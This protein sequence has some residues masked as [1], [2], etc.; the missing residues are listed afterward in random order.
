MNSLLGQISIT[1]IFVILLILAAALVYKKRYRGSG[2]ISVEEYLSFGPRRGIAAVKVGKEILIVGIT[3]NE[4]RLLKI[5]DEEMTTALKRQKENEQLSLKELNFSS[6][7]L[8]AKM[9][10]KI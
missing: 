4:F 5:L 2:L 1:L 6:F 3:P 7:L 9:N 8:G 10:K